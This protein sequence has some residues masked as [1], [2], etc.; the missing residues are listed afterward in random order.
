MGKARGA[1][2]LVVLA[3]LL[4]TDGQILL[5]AALVDGEDMVS[6]RT[7]KP[8]WNMRPPVLPL[9]P[10]TLV[11]RGRSGLLKF[12]CAGSFQGCTQSLAETS[13]L[14]LCPHVLGP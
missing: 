14:Q 2:C 7:Q 11:C 8:V 12:H 3:L 10:A 1:T 5:S 13:R 9:I 6:M 4:E